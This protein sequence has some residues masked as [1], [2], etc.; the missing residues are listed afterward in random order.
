MTHSA[1]TFY[2]NIFPAHGFRLFRGGSSPA[3]ISAIHSGCTEDI[4]S[5]SHVSAHVKHMHR[6][7]RGRHVDLIR[8]LNFRTTEDRGAGGQ[9]Q[10]RR[11]RPSRIKKRWLPQRGQRM[12]HELH[13]GERATDR[14]PYAS[15][16][17]VPIMFEQCMCCQSM[18][19]QMIQIIMQLF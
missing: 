1:S 4:D 14:T 16:T 17:P 8:Q 19:Y 5:Y 13:T 6:E 9:A 11:R 3:I 7:G 12:R 10:P 15:P 18:A 2:Q